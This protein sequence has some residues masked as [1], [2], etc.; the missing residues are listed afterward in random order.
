MLITL[1]E[2]DPPVFEKQSLELLHALQEKHQQMPRF[3]HMIG[4]NHLSVALY[5][6]L[7]DDLLAPQLRSF[8]HDNGDDKPQELIRHKA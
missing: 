5:L 8:I 7:E 3:V 4:H 2:N 6:G 1:A